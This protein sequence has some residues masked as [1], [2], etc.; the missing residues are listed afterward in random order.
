MSL[1]CFICA[2]DFVTKLAV[3]CES[4]G[5]MFGFHVVP[6]QTQPVVLIVAQW[7]EIWARVQLL[8]KLFK[9]LRSIEGALKHK[10]MVRGNFIE[11]ILHMI[12]IFYLWFRFLWVW[13]ALF[14]P[15]ILSQ[16]WQLYVNVL[17]KC[18]DSTWFLTTLIRFS[19]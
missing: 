9:I 15:K 6:D 2:K 3:V 8:N 12:L 16:N 4:I 5:I 13:N 1:K 19:W 17:G 14:V 10:I 18:L 7:T 11:F